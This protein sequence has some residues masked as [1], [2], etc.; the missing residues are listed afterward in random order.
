MRFIAIFYVF[1]SNF[2][3]ASL[4]FLMCL[5][6]LFNV[7]HIHFQRPFIYETFVI[8]AISAT[9]FVHLSFFNV[10]YL[11]HLRKFRRFATV[12]KS[13]VKEHGETD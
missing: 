11:H 12:N 1:Y 5:I 8:Y 2:Q 4:L 13:F 6:A 10:I 9:Y 3:C 7:L